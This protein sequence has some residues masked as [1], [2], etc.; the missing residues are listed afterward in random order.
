MHGAGVKHT[1]LR[2]MHPAG[3]LAIENDCWGSA[4][5]GALP[6]SAGM[7]LSIRRREKIRGSPDVKIEA[8]AFVT[9]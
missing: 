4:I 6:K 7:A 1:W 2:D 5:Q 8:C 9:A 3:G